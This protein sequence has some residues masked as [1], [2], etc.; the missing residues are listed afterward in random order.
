MTFF[1]T[2]KANCGRLL[3]LKTQLYWYN[4][5]GWDNFPGRVCLILDADRGWH[6]VAHADADGALAAAC[7]LLLIDGSPTWVWID[8]QSAELIT[9]E[10][11]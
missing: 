3:R 7:V 9:S 5:R 8:K 4:G 2:L 11:S 6:R 1:E 10:A